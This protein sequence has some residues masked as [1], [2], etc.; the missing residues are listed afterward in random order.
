MKTGWSEIDGKLSFFDSNGKMTSVN[1]FNEMNN[2][3]DAEIA[4]S[5]LEKETEQDVTKNA[6]SADPM[7]LPDKLSDAAQSIQQAGSGS[8]SS[9]AAVATPGQQTEI[10]P[11]KYNSSDA[12]NG[13]TIDTSK[14]EVGSGGEG[15]VAMPGEENSTSSGTGRIVFENPN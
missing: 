3:S 12:V 5:L 8:Q 15:E 9:A 1:S 14:L 13:N 6:P 4:A 11:G 10:D 2:I 7:P